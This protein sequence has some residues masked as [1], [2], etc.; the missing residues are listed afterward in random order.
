MAL[1]GI[2]LPLA[3]VADADGVQVAVVEPCK[4]V[5]FL[6]TGLT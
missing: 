1:K 5:K 6:L 4:G 2:P 3:G